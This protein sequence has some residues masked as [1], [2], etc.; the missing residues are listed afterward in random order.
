MK[1]TINKNDIFLIIVVLALALILSVVIDFSQGGGEYVTV[2][3]AGKIIAELP[4]D[5]D[6]SFEIT[7]GSKVCNTVRIKNKS[8][9]VVSADCPDKICVK[10]RSI[11]KNNESIICLPNKVVVSVV[12]EKENDVDGVAG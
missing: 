2:E 12:S 10:H 5:K 6:A 11:S 7:N 3:Q 1:K 4:I 9:S 8:V